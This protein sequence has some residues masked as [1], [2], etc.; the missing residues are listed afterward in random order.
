MKNRFITMLSGMAALF[1]GGV[2]PSHTPTQNAPKL[3]S[4][5]GQMQY[6]REH[7]HGTMSR[8]IA[9]NAVMGRFKYA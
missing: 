7:K 1:T 4:I 8:R 5:N 3:G 6:R 9:R 2:T